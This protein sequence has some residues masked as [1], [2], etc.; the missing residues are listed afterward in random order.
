MELKSRQTY[1]L[2][3]MLETEKGVAPEEF[4]EKL[5]VGKRTLYYDLENIN[6]WLKHYKLGKLVISGQII[7]AEI[8]D[9][10]ALEQQLRQGTMY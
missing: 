5:G 2:R 3:A 9:A 8:P 1:I 10:A 6:D 4:L 7:R